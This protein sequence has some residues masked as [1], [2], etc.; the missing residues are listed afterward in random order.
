MT[1]REVWGSASSQSRGAVAWALGSLLLAGLPFVGF[2]VGVVA[3][4]QAR[5]A[6]G[7]DVDE[8]GDPH[9]VAA[10]GMLLAVLGVCLGLV[11]SGALLALLLIG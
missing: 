9:R 7:S 6:R 2:A 3:V 10:V 5:G 11:F 1:W 8:A 4:V